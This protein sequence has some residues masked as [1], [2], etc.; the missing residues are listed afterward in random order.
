M[1][2]YSK[3]TYLIQSSRAQSVCSAKQ[4]IVITAC[5]QYVVALLLSNYVY[6]YYCNRHNNLNINSL[7][8]FANRKWT[9]NCWFGPIPT[10]L[11]SRVETKFSSS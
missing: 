10:D 4:K 2:E 5:R 1:T 11:R 9:L 6:Y 7:W 3:E 8:K